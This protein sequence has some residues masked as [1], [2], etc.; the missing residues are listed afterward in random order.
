[1][2][3]GDV[4]SGGNAV[5][6]YLAHVKDLNAVVCGLAADDNVVLVPPELSPDNRLCL[7][8]LGQTAEVDKLSISVDFG[9]CSTVCLRN[10]HKLATVRACPAPGRRA[11]TGLAAEVGMAD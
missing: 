3:A 4:D 7:G 6:A 10:G 2:S 5:K 9:K 11:L 8:G 1:M